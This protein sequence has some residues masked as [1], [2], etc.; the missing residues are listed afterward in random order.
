MRHLGQKWLLQE[1]ILAIGLL[2]RDPQAARAL[3]T[4]LKL[5]TQASIA[6]IRRLIYNLRPPILDEWGL[7]AALHEQVA[8][9]QLN[10]V[11]VCVEA[12]ESLPP[13]PAAVEVAAYR[14]ALEALANAVRH[15]HASTCIIHLALS[16]DALTVEVRDNGEG[17]PEDYHPGVGISAMRERAAELGGSCM[18]ETMTTG[19]TR[20]SARL[21]R[22]KE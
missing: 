1:G 4:D 19:G 17:L 7:M 21:P 10:H 13:L 9:Y 5:Q 14:I 6:D 11:Q 15:A 2:E 3:L 12:P 20:V 18:V 22:P 8:Q 16:D